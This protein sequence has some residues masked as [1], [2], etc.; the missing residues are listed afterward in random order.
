V[1]VNGKI[2]Y[3]NGLLTWQN[4]NWSTVKELLIAEP[5]SAETD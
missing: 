5:V 1:K 4:S 3:E 2:I